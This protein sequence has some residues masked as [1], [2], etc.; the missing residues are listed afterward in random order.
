MSARTIISGLQMTLLIRPSIG[1]LLAICAMASSAQTT[2]PAATGAAQAPTAPAASAPAATAAT[3][4]SSP[5]FVVT[6]SST[7]LASFGD[8]KITQADYE[9]WVIGTIPER[10]RFGWAMNQ[11]NITKVINDLLRVRTVAEVAKKRGLEADPIYRLRVAQYQEKLLQEAMLQRV[12]EEAN[13]EFEQKRAAFTERAREQFL[14]NKGRYQRPKEV[15]T[16]HI[17]VDTRSRNAEQALAKIKVLRE[18]ALAGEPFDKLAEANSDDPTAKA[19]KGDIGFF[20]PGRMDPAFESAAFALKKPM[21]ISEPIKTQF[22][23]H[24]IRLDDTKAAVQLTFEEALPDLMETLRAQYVVTRQAQVRDS[25]YDPSKV[26]WNEPAVVGLRKTV[27]PA[28]FKQHEQH[29]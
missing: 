25:Y 27:D 8:I 26:K 13:R 4:A 6:G 29:K 11:G 23:W 16:S 19:N 21:E 20:G 5:A 2:A 12:E 24:I 22:G 18:R 3:A 14:V 7:V 17:L 1:A 10:D 28:V 15:K 9:A